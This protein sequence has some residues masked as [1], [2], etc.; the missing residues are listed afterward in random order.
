MSRKI[1][2]KKTQYFTELFYTPQPQ[3][4]ITHTDSLLLSHT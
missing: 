1:P 3:V 2:V 4:M